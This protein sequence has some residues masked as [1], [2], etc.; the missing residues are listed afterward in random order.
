MHARRRNLFETEKL[1]SKQHF[2]TNEV[3][4]QQPQ[5]QVSYFYSIVATKYR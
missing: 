4:Q 5:E 3:I 2:D 1:I